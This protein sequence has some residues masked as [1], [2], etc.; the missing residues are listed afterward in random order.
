M[1]KEHHMELVPPSHPT[2]LQNI[3]E[4]PEKYYSSWSLS[5][6][7]PE[8]LGVVKLPTTK[9]SQFLWNPWLRMTQIQE[10]ATNFYTFFPH[11]TKIKMVAFVF[12]SLLCMCHPWALV[13]CDIY[14]G[15]ESIL[16][17]YA[18]S[19]HQNF[20]SVSITFSVA[21]WK[22]FIIKAN[23]G[24]TSVNCVI[25]ASWVPSKTVTLQEI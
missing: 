1:V 15:L 22:G 24:S 16:P 13:Q 14:V 25:P 12:V 18:L 19:M 23:E 6:S 5:L 21:K 9:Y 8:R 10:Y 4:C 20:N 3:T 7:W 17:R 11:P 2:E